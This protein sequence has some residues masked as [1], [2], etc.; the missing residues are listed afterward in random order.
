MDIYDEMA[1]ASSSPMLLVLEWK[2]Y[3]VVIIW[4]DRSFY[5][6]SSGHFFEA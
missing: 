4:N 2:K 1:M 5:Q 6:G 3:S